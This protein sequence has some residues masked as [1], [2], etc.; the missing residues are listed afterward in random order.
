MK[1]TTFWDI[2]QCSPLKVKQRFEGGYRLHLQG[3]ISRASSKQSLLCGLQAS[4]GGR[5]RG[6]GGKPWHHLIS[7][8]ML[9]ALHILSSVILITLITLWKVQIKNISIMQSSPPFFYF[10]SFG[11]ICTLSAH[12]SQTPPVYILPLPVIAFWAIQYNMQQ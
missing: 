1:C 8:C 7:P 4:S 2:R 5:S 9:Y 3:R 10:L 11:S 12:Y 6:S